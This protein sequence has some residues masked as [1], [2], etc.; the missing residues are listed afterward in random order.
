MV[1]AVPARPE[2]S[3]PVGCDTGTTSPSYR[4][5]GRISAGLPDDWG[6][7]VRY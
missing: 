7:P 1:P 2:R 5:T 3:Q 4:M 6:R